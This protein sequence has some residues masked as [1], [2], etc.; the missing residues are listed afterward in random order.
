MVT[1]SW[2]FTYYHIIYREHGCCKW[3]LYSVSGFCIVVK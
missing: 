3:L 2:C 1:D